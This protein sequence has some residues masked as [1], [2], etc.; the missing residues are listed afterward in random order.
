[1]TARSV[2]A[3]PIFLSVRD[4]AF[5]SYDDLR[6]IVYAPEGAMSFDRVSNICRRNRKRHINCLNSVAI[7]YHRQGTCK[8]HPRFAAVR[9]HMMVCAVNRFSVG[10]KADLLLEIMTHTSIALPGKPDSQ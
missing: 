10:L 4:L 1:M 8:S 2:L 7:I 5:A 9:D 3:V 6:P